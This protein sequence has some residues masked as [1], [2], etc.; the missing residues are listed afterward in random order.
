MVVMGN[1][2]ATDALRLTVNQTNNLKVKIRFR[3]AGPEV[4]SH[5]AF[6]S[7]RQRTVFRRI[8]RCRDFAGIFP[9]NSGKLQNRRTF[10]LTN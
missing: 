1:A 4:L 6:A 7:I 2:L 8:P 9:A 3:E 5:I 10:L